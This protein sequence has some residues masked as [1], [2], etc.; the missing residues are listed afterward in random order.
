MGGAVDGISCQDVASTRHMIVIRTGR[1]SDL[2]QVYGLPSGPDADTVDTVRFIR[3]APRDSRLDFVVRQ[4]GRQTAGN[5]S[6]ASESVLFLHGRNRD[7]RLT[8]CWIPGSR[9]F[10]FSPKQSRDGRYPPCTAVWSSSVVTWRFNKESL[11]A[12]SLRWP[13]KTTD[14]VPPPPVRVRVAGIKRFCRSGT[15][16]GSV[17]LLVRTQGSCQQAYNLATRRANKQKICKSLG[18]NYKFVRDERLKTS[19]CR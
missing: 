15:G 14:P 10:T 3:I 9:V 5:F 16:T 8:V 4:N 6:R 12:E 19:T 17:E 11:P 2:A 7:V 1:E 18:S 13:P